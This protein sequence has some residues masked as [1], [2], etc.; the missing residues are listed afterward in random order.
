MNFFS[1]YTNFK[2]LFKL[3][4]ASG[5]PV[6]YTN[7]RILGFVEEL[8]VNDDPEY[9]LID[10]FRTPRASNEARQTLFSKMSGGY[11]LRL[12]IFY[13]L[14]WDAGCWQGEY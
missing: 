3:F 10:K 13:F 8:L 11:K 5:I 12:R 6:G 2:N 9:Q 1:F 7:V 14:F 4:L